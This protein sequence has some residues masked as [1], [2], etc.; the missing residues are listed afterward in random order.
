M[1]LHSPTLASG[2]LLHAFAIGIGD[3]FNSHKGIIN[4]KKEKPY[5]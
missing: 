5:A 4:Y 3:L 2:K 1:T